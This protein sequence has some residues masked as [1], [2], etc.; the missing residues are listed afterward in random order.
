MARLLILMVLSLTSSLAFSFSVESVFRDQTYALFDPEMVSV[1]VLGGSLGKIDDGYVANADLEI[2]INASREELLASTSNILRTRYVNYKFP[3]G[4][5]NTKKDRHLA[6]NILS[7]GIAE[8][9]LMSTF[10]SE[11][12]KGKVIY[13]PKSQLKL[14]EETDT[15]RIYLVIFGER[16]YVSE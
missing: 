16:I 9:I 7:S 12:K 5:N 2:T 13:R 10:G 3:E 8:F 15:G 11:I 4:I 6:D 1:K 14:S